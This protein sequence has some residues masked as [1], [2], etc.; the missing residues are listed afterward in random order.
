MFSTDTLAS[1][2]P[3]ATF[4]VMAAQPSS[5]S[6]WLMWRRPLVLALIMGA[7]VSLAMTGTLTAR[8]L[9]S[10]TLSWSFVPLIEVVALAM[11][12]RRR[13]TRGA[14]A[15]H[16]DVFFAGF[17][18]WYLFFIGIA[19]VPAAPLR[20]SQIA[21]GWLEYVGTAILLWSLYVDYCYFRYAVGRTSGEAR[22]DV[23]LHRALSWMP[24]LLII[25]APGLW[26]TVRELLSRGAI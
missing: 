11:V 5:S 21:F 17:S 7:M 14:L 16:V 12:L 25:G 22:G 1:F 19:L 23:F 18:I 15:T 4:R 13:A 26:P 20:F 2:R 24:I 8:L 9:L 3:A 6:F 10:G